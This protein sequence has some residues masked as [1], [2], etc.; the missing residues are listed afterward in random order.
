[1]QI[2]QK[3][4]K[5]NFRSFLWHS[6]FLAL[7]TNFM[8]VDTIIPSMLIKAGGTSV[9]LGILTAI[10]IGGTRIFQL[11]FASYLSKRTFKKKFLLIG[12][13]LRVLSLIVLG[14]IFYKSGTFNGDLLIFMIFLLISVFSL[15]G[16]YSA[17]SYND[18]L[19]KSIIQES[20]KYFFALKQIVSSTGIFIS[21]WIVRHLIKRLE[22]PDNYALLFIIAGILLLTASLGFWNVREAYYKSIQR[23][24]II[25]FFRLIPSEIK[26]NPNLKNY[27]LIINSL[28]L[29]LSILPFLILFAK[30][31]FSLSYAL[32][33][34][35]L[36]FKVI[37]MLTGS[38]TYYKIAHKINYKTLLKFSLI[39]G[40]IL[41]IL[42]LS[43]STSQFLYQFLFIFSGIF[44]AVYK[45]SSDGV[46]MEISTNENRT[47]YTGIAG[48]GNLLTV[49]FPL[50]AGF[51][52]KEFDYIAVFSSVSILIFASYF[53]VNRLDCKPT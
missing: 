24:N 11:I 3:R 29:G 42:A 38:L 5:I 10:M 20:R 6:I 30:E 1:M 46:L 16:S 41:P 13:N 49:L 37:G 15:S 31:N 17:I 21:A 44:F 48:A 50:V 35:I 2:S 27:L 22:Y 36:L 47:L 7:A 40:G 28:G 43:L 8:D 45:I 33:G 53:F 34:N 4:S 25:D 23:K 12:V 32:I 19:G 14:I 9:H 51:L 39:I 26:T 18:I 52:I